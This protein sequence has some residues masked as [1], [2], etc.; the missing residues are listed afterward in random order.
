[1]KSKLSMVASQEAEISLMV[2]MKYLE[3]VIRV[4]KVKTFC[5]LHRGAFMPFVKTELHASGKILQIIA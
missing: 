2:M 3:L 4:Q 5:T 1:M